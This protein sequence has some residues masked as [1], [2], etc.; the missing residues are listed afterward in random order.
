MA[1]TFRVTTY[2]FGPGTFSGQVARLSLRATL[3]PNY[4]VMISPEL[5]TDGSSGPGSAG[6]RVSA[7][8]YG[9]G[10]LA[11]ADGNYLELTREASDLDWTG[12]VTV[13]ESLRDHDRGGFRLLD[14]K[15]TALAALSG[16]AEITATT[17][18]SNATW[19][20]SSRLVLFGGPRGGGFSC[21]SATSTCWPAAGVRLWP[22]GTATLN[23]ERYAIDPSSTPAVTLTT[24]V[25]EWG[26]AW[27][28]RRA[29]IR[30]S[31]AGSGIDAITEYVK[32]TFGASGGD[33]PRL[34]SQTMWAWWD[35]QDK[36]TFTFSVGSTIATWGDKSGLG[37]TLSVLVTGAPTRT[38]SDANFNDAASVAFTADVISTGST[39]PFNDFT[40]MIA[41]RITTRTGTKALLSGGSL[42]G[43]SVRHNATA[44]TVGGLFVSTSAYNPEFYDGDV[45]VMTIRRSGSTR[46]IWR[47]GKIVSTGSCD[48]TTTTDSAIAVGGDPDGSN[49]VVSFQ[50]AEVCIWQGALS[51]DETR[52]QAHRILRKVRGAPALLDRFTTWAW[53]SGWTSQ[54]GA[55]EAWTGSVPVLG[56][57]VTAGSNEWLAGVGQGS[58]ADRRF[59]V[60]ALSH[61][62]V[63]ASWQ[64]HASGDGTAQTYAWTVGVPVRTE[65]RGTDE[66]GVTW[67]EGARF[68]LQPAS[69]SSTSTSLHSEVLFAARHTADTT[70]TVR[71]GDASPT[72]VWSAWLQNVDLGSVGFGARSVGDPVF[73]VT[74]YRIDGQFSGTTYDL[75]MEN[76]LSE[77]YFVMI[78]G[79][80]ADTATPGANDCGARVT[81]D[82][83][84]TGD[85]AVS[86]GANVLRLER[87]ASATG[88]WFG[89]VTIVECLVA[90][91]TDGFRLRDVKTV[92][93]AT[94]GSTTGSQV[95]TTTLNQALTTTGRG[96][97]VPFAGVRGG[98]WTT[99]ASGADDLPTAGAVFELTANGT[100]TT[101]RRQ[102]TADTVGAATFTA[103]VVEWGSRWVVQKGRLDG[104]AIASGGTYVPTTI[105]VPVDPSA[106]WTWASVASTGDT[107]DESWQSA[108]VVLGDGSGVASPETSVSV[109]TGAA[110]TIHALAYVLSHPN[111]V[112]SRA[113]QGS[114]GNLFSVVSIDAPVAGEAR[115]YSSA[116]LL[117]AMGSRIVATRTWQDDPT[118][119]APAASW[120]GIATGDVT[121]LGL[122]EYPV[123]NIEGWYQ[124]ADF[125]GIRASEVTTSAF[126]PDGYLVVRDP[127]I[128]GANLVVTATSSAGA[129][130]GQAVPASTNRGTVIAF[131]EG[132]PTG[133]TEIDL[134]IVRGGSVAPYLGSSGW[135]VGGY[136]WRRAGETRWKGAN[137]PTLLM[138]HA[139]QHLSSAEYALC[140]CYSSVFRRVLMARPASSTTVTI[141]YR[142]V[143]ASQTSTWTT[144]TLTVPDAKSG[145]QTGIE[146]L[147]TASGRLLLFVQ[148]SGVVSY[149][150]APGDV[151]LFGSDDGGDTWTSVSVGLYRKTAL[152]YLQTATIGGQFRADVSGDWIRLTSLQTLLSTVDNR[153][154]LTLVSPDRGG[155]WKYLT[156]LSIYSFKSA[157][158]STV[159]SFPWSIVGVGDGSGTFLLA[160]LTSSASTIVRIYA[161]SRDGAWS[162]QSSL[163][164]TYNSTFTAG[165]T[166]FSSP[167]IKG[168]CFVRTP[169]SIRLYTWVEGSDGSEFYCHL[170]D[171]NNPLDAT[172]WSPLGPITAFGGTLKYGPYHWVARWCGDH[173]VMAG[174][175]FNP[176]VNTYTNDAVVAGMF[177]A[178]LGG[179]DARPVH[180][181][182]FLYVQFFD[183]PLL[184]TAQWHTAQG[185]LGPV[186]DGSADANT[187]WTYTTSG[188]NTRSWAADWSSSSSN[189]STGYGNWNISLGTSD[190]GGGCLVLPIQIPSQ[191]VDPT[192]L[193]MGIRIRP[194]STTAGNKIDVTVRVGTSKIIVWD[195]IAGASLATLTSVPG[196]SGYELRIGWFTTTIEVSYRPLTTLP[197]VDVTTTGPLTATGGGAQAA[198][199]IDHGL[200][201]SPATAGTST[202]KIKE[203]S[204]F[205]SWNLGQLSSV[206]TNPDDLTGMPTCRN[207]VN[208]A[209]GI[210]ARWGG[211]GSFDA[212]S[213][214]IDVEFDRGTIALRQ[215]SPQLI[216]ESTDLAVQHLVFDAGDAASRWID[217]VLVLIGTVDRTAILEFSDTDSWS[218]P[219]SSYDLSADL[220]SD[221]EVVEVNGAAVR[222]SARSGS[223]PVR[224]EATTRFIRFVIAGSATGKTYEIRNDPDDSGG[225][226]HLDT[227]A[228][229]DVDVG[230]VPGM[231]ATIYGDRM[232]WRGTDFERHRFF[233]ITFP[234]LAAGGTSTGTHR[235]GAVLPG[236][237]VD[238]AVPIEWTWKDSEQPNTS[239]IRTRAGAS[240]V[241][242]EGPSQRVIEGRIVGDFTERERDELRA[243]IGKH[244]GYDERPIALIVDAS[245][246]ADSV[247]YGR[248]TA[249]SVK[250]NAAWYLDDDGNWRSAGDTDLVIAEEA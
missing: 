204:F 95:T 24:Y 40:A 172:A 163:D 140:V 18:T 121:L 190:S 213:F 76:D 30:G 225:W 199:L 168:L 8:P 98:G 84:G 194:Y 180:L 160:C 59:D 74:T 70:V 131:V 103:H 189:S 143:A 22:T 206:T 242:R 150:A 240:W 223:L 89:V 139:P 162:A 236:V 90:G 132:T 56:D 51:D 211:S 3:T 102:G 182:R 203:F 184:S 32:S 67:T 62:D 33:D 249:G 198:T 173:V 165:A 97:S 14:A 117:Y 133:T 169:D 52:S 120:Q 129:R 48:N 63:S 55:G 128:D 235:L 4:F 54:D 247:I 19:E 2:E 115:G 176:D 35:A 200:L 224:G 193:D 179:W 82:P 119:G 227:T 174:G 215:D 197:E 10:D 125:G 7:D 31:A 230:I 145:T 58:T 87:D 146:M 26:D 47:D 1:N 29:T 104:V 205:R 152:G 195:N 188:T 65:T 126:G 147:E 155:T 53:G 127:T 148:T 233:R 158:N 219:A 116:G 130:V 46:T 107:A 20:D 135:N 192:T 110:A 191:R 94:M 222:L 122:R 161:A 37:N 153:G 75:T 238:L 49:S 118:A 243:L 167:L 105:G 228:D 36:S 142:D 5:E 170:V 39:V 156:N 221:L 201:A 208:V 250:D 91:D 157:A 44:N 11:R 248:W 83:F 113:S 100:L 43:W 28:V 34:L 86:S 141:Y 237:A 112:A 80:R 220:W 79:C 178:K 12:T 16:T 124:I 9:T 166:T 181:T 187:P 217:D 209:D 137:A 61:P 226:Y 210:L 218:Y 185:I 77:D 239:S 183:K 229:L 96:R 17:D 231:T 234:A 196:T 64:F 85:L 71:R 214:A 171:A 151:Y 92:S 21:A 108:V 66:F 136:V 212:D 60:V 41:F 27:D 93:C 138:G 78:E 244:S 134:Q 177:T 25:V 38:A 69:I 88:E 241:Y 23:F 245:R 73:R 123:G 207:P 57:G 99:S 175:L 101:T 68:A 81:K 144:V 45:H 149:N 50:V 42:D 114:V 186:A 159:G 246:P 109:T 72:Q 154:V 15:V 111:L 106:T 216:W 13:V 232:V 6:A 202:Y 164:L